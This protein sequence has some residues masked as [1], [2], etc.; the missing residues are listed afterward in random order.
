MDTKVASFFPN[1]HTAANVAKSVQE[2]L[3]AMKNKKVKRE[4]KVK[5]KKI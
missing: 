4:F 3:A 1:A 5:K 2:S